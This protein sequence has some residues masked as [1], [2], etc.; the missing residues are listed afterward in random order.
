[1]CFLLSKRILCVC[2][3]SSLVVPWTGSLY[4]PWLRQASERV[5]IPRSSSES[6]PEILRPVSH[7][8]CRVLWGVQ[9]KNDPASA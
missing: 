7:W 9:V 1:M 2:M 5:D 8:M 3:V 4:S 6:I